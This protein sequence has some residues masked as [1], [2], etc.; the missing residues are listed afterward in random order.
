MLSRR[1]LLGA[2][3][4]ALSGLRAGLRAEG[5]ALGLRAIAEARGVLFG[6]AAGSYQL[7]DGDFQAALR[8]EAA[9]LVP[10]FEQV[11][12]AIEPEPGRFDF[13]GADLLTSFAARSGLAMH[14]HTLVWYAANPKWLDEKVAHAPDDEIFTYYIARVMKH[15]AGACRSWDVVNEAILPADG[16]A[17]GL[18][19]TQWLKRF[20]PGYIDTAFHA[21]KQADPKA[22][23]VYSDWG[24]EGGEPWN[25]VF[26]AKTLD[27]LEGAKA[28]GVPVEALGL[29][30]HLNAFGPPV[31]QAKLRTFLE[32]VKA[33]GL[34]I[35]VTELDVDDTKAPREITARDQA[36]ADA[37]A[38]FLDVVMDNPATVAVL[39]WGLSDRY[40]PRPA[41]L[42]GYTPRKLPL[43]TDLG[44]KP[45]W[46][47][48]ARAFGRRI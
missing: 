41:W 31:D 37:T 39:T 6:T 23:L 14:G 47:A 48:I 17:D 29:Q 15:Y 35:L 9:I 34:K 5:A 26:R 24:C 12:E 7:K 33:L 11:R 40:L 22:L 13:A 36:V 10:E 20:G 28:R 8:R 43:D 1:M 30:G 3:T 45:M 46:N 4:A 44:R 25:D 38:R 18:R 27:F 32:R 2:G 42:P 19:A 21:A 16:R